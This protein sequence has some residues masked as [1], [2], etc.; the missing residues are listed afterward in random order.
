PAPPVTRPKPEAT[1]RPHTGTRTPPPAATVKS[2]RSPVWSSPAP[3]SEPKVSRSCTP[4][5]SPKTPTCW[6]ASPAPTAT[7]THDDPYDGPLDQLTWPRHAARLTLRPATAAEV[8]ATWAFRRLDSVSQWLTRA[9]RT[10]DEYS[11]Q[12]DDPV[13]G[14]ARC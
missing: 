3:A 8:K 4:P 1:S 13:R 2:W 9:P 5:S 10:F 6:R 7:R 14:E 11:A 12:F